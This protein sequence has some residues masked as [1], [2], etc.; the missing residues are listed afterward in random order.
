MFFDKGQEGLMLKDM[1]EGLKLSLRFNKY[2]F[3]Y[4]KIELAIL[5]LGNLSMLLGLVNP[6]IGKLILDKGIL[7]KDINSLVIFSIL[8]VGIFVTTLIFSIGYDY[9]KNYAVVRIEAD[10]NREVLT[11]IKMQSL[12]GLQKIPS[13]THLFRIT[14]DITSAANIIN[15]TLIHFIN[16]LL[17]IIFITA[18][19]FF[20]NPVLLLIVLAYQILVIVKMKLLIK[21]ME[22]LSKLSLQKTEGIYRTLGSLFSHLYLFKAFGTVAREIQRYVHSL[23]EYKRLQMKYAKIRSFSNFLIS[24]ADKLFFGILSFYGAILVIQRR[25]TLGTL[26]AVIMYISQGTGAYS[27]LMNMAGELVLNK[28][29]LERLRNLLDQ[30]IPTQHISIAKSRPQDIRRIEFK[31]VTFSYRPERKILKDLNFII[32]S[33]LHIGLVGY[34]GCGKTTLINLFLDLYQPQTGTIIIGDHDLQEVD[35]CYLL[36]KVGLVLQEP[37]LLDD[38]IANNISYA[39]KKVSREE[40]VEAARLVDAIEFINSLPHGF[41]TEVGENAYSLSQGQKQR[42]SIARAII[43]EPPILILDEAM[44][45]LDPASEARIIET[46]KK[47]FNNSTIIVVSHRLTAIEKMDMIYF[48]ESPSNMNIGTHQGLIERDSG[49]REFFANQNRLP[50]GADYKL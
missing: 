18:I 43:K 15:V 29:P 49:Y 37:F 16:S 41:N 23:F 24:I 38:T 9:L 10:L 50:E 28:I 22:K 21:P 6:Y 34:S 20:I 4:W 14:N 32:E 5:V 33:G 13:A 7:A 26:G 17:K 12:G 39:L 30:P 40:I 48:F 36:A 44:S 2:I 1:K 11:R 46:L 25:I 19:I 27:T 8:A 3:R 42:I 47:R 31:D 35:S 45:S